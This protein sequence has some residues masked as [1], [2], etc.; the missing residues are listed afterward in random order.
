ME[1]GKIALKDRLLAGMAYFNPLLA[2]FISWLYFKDRKGFA[3]FHCNQALAFGFVLLILSVAAFAAIP[4]LYRFG[5]SKVGPTDGYTLIWLVITLP[6]FA[7]AASGMR[8]RVP[9]ACNLADWWLNYIEGSM[10]QAKEAKK[11]K[12]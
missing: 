2:A 10:A 8:F 9:I 1:N 6:F 4:G 12:V 11:K 5:I 7:A 3:Y